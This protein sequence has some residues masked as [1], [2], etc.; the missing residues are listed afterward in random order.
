MRT[1]DFRALLGG[2]DS[3]EGLAKRVALLTEVV[4]D[5][6]VEVEALRLERAA[7]AARTGDRTYAEAY[8]ASAA[9]AHNGAGVIPGSFK[10][11]A[12]FYGGRD[13][14]MSTDGRPLREVLLLRRLG[15]SDEQLREFAEHIRHVEELS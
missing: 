5:L 4:F 6:L 8:Q 7:H 14:E 1:H 9:V 3:Y 15:L 11:L 10:L 13:E 12:R 2:D